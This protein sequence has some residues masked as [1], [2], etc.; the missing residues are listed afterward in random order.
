MPRSRPVPP[1]QPTIHAPQ[2]PPVQPTT[3]NFAGFSIVIY[4][5]NSA[6]AVP[7]LP[8]RPAVAARGQHTV[9]DH[10]LDDL[11]LD[12]FASDF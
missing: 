7:P 1:V 12:M 3:M 10:E 8:P 9:S 2:M 5:E 4:Q 11:D 6:P